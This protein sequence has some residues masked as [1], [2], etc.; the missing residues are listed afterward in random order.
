MKLNKEKIKRLEK[1]SGHNVAIFDCLKCGENE[2]KVR[3][4]QI[5][6]NTGLCHKCAIRKRPH[7]QRYN[8]FKDSVLRTNKRRNR[9][10]CFELTYEQYLEFTKI[11][12]C[13]YCNLP[14][15]WTPHYDKH[16]KQRGSFIDRKDSN[17]GYTPNNCVVCC[18][19]CNR[20]KNKFFSHEEF[21][22]IA[23]IL[24]KYRDG[25]FIYKEND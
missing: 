5:E 12:N 11:T 15:P 22:E 24:D 2:I 17:I 4:T 6:N 1:H 18:G 7:E 21:I 19:R 3:P 16:L 9:E 13:E 10:I 20:I 14:I 25:K 8:H 23:K